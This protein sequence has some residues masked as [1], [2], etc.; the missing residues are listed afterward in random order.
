[1]RVLLVDD[2]K[3]IR[4]TLGDALHDAGHHVFTAETGTEALKMLA[5]AKFDCVITDMRLPGASGMEILARVKEV[6]E[7][8][9][10]IVITGYGTIESAVEAT[11]AG[12]TEYITK[13]FLNDDVLVR[14]ERIS[15][16]KRL[17]DENRRLR[18][19]LT[20]RF[21][22]ENLIGSSSEMKAVF[23]R[24]NTVADSEHSVLITGESG[25]GKEVVARAIHHSSRRSAGPFEALSCGASAPTLVED[26]LFGH[27]RGAFTDAKERRMGRFERADEGT[28]FLD[29]IDDMPLPT[30]VKLLRV[31]EERRFERLGG[32]ETIRV[33]I[34]VIA[35]T[36]RDLED[37][38]AGGDF[39]EDLFYR[40]NV[41]PLA[42]PPLRQRLED[43]PE[44]VEHFI[45]LHGGEGTY[46]VEPETF[47]AMAG[48]EWPGNVR[49]LENAVKR[50][51][52]LSTRPG[53][54]PKKYLVPTPPAR[55]A[56]LAAGAASLKGVAADA[57]VA[58]IIR[59]LVE[60]EGNKAKAARALGISRKSL[61]RKMKD[62]G[63]EG[64]R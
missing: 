17:R 25:T 12:A 3:S 18:G 35:A 32:S 30:Q 31:L 51:I 23:D 62:L 29:D 54:L 37:L 49:E 42:L 38:V 22:F 52:A 13:P 45:R 9:H 26:E 8:T 46:R 6:A 14:L 10:V 7:S 61:W 20:G 47:E 19:E 11:K 39:R 33:D 24:V 2:E 44:L 16:E 43:L 57:Q 21:K 34:R 50:A 58:L 36:K 41:V 27:E 60:A 4:M 40:L 55:P 53:V 48:Y 15:E 59:V 5:T 56:E 1:M 28:L 64:Y 63:M